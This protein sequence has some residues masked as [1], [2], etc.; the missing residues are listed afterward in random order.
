MR[1]AALSIAGTDPTGGA[2][3]QA[4][5]QVFAVCGVHGMAVP[6]A[7]IEQDSRGVR[8]VHA[9]F[10]SLVESQIHHCFEDSPP[11]AVKI[12][13]LA[14]DDI[15]HAVAR[16]LERAGPAPLVLDPVLKSSSGAFLLERRGWDTL[17]GALL[18][19]V[20]VLTPNLAEAGALLEAEPPATPDAM[21]GAARALRALGASW[22]LIKGGHLAGDPID[23]LVGEG[24]AR[25]FR[26]KRVD[27]EVHGTG[28][29]LSSAIAA[30]LAR[31]MDVP[32]AVERAHAYLQ[33]AIAG[34]VQRGPEISR[35]GG[36]KGRRTLDFGARYEAGEPGG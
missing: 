21:A 16:A 10:P 7:L 2:G 9:V 26:G 15:V 24:E 1:P 31:G 20:T 12:G 27:A 25:T 32:A 28:C 29:A 6:T 13:A 33:R 8:R 11:A 19:R 36:A 30:G 34:S 3:I 14:T 23:V 4:D 18:P 35:A 17:R 5:L 22:V